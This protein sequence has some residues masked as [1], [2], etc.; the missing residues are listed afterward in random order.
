MRYLKIF[1]TREERENAF[2]D[3]DLSKNSVTIIGSSDVA[4]TGIG[5]ILFGIGNEEHA[6]NLGYNDYNENDT[7]S[8]SFDD[9]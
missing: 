1:N 2:N 6:I 3:G 7:D 9:E 5:D 8:S 4:E